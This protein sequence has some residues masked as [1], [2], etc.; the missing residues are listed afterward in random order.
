MTD[1]SVDTASESEKVTPS[2]LKSSVPSD[3]L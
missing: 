3:S 2:D 1:D